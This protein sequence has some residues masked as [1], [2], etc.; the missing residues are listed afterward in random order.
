[1]L[2]LP[3]LL[4]KGD[5]S[6]WLDKGGTKETLLS[7]AD[8]APDFTPDIFSEYLSQGTGKTG[9]TTQNI[10]SREETGAKNSESVTDTTGKTGKN[11]P[12]ASSE[13]PASDTP[14]TFTTAPGPLETA[15]LPVP[16]LTVDMLPAALRGWLHDAAV[17]TSVPLEYVAAPA[18]IALAGALGRKVGIRP[19][20]FDHWTVV[21]VLWGAC[22]GRPGTLKTPATA[23]GFRH[24]NR[25]EVDARTEYDAA[26]KKHSMLSSVQESRKKAVKSKLD[27][28][29]KK[30]ASNEAM[31]QI[32]NDAD[33]EAEEEPVCRRYIVNDTTVEK[34]G[35]LLKENA[36][37]LVMFRDELTSFFRSLDK[38][39]HEAD[40]GF[41][42][43]AWNGT[44]AYTYHRIG[45]GTVV[46]PAPCVSLYGTIQPGPMGA[47]K[48]AESWCA[49]FP[50]T[51]ET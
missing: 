1:V 31:M 25:L 46:I 36:Q 33:A 3:K 29:A 9:K 40:K 49:G 35:E 39:G 14:P 37:G 32:I 48:V 34:L 50:P 7:L 5:V 8:I 12:P 10:E 18:I 24:L 6:D 26:L 43:Q 4:P 23:E 17:R 20:R 2:E 13:T 47:D 16:R 41:Y 42:L 27:Q 21:P 15:L 11:N 44:G 22:V 45:R 30:N 28:A 38:Q 51:K 19:K